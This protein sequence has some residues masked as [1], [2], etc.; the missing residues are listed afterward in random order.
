[1]QKTIEGAQNFKLASTVTINSDMAIHKD[2]ILPL[3]MLVIFGVLSFGM[4]LNVKASIMVMNIM[5]MDIYGLILKVRE[6]LSS[7]TLTAL[8]QKNMNLESE[9]VIVNLWMYSRINGCN[10]L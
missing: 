3:L 1:M 5:D 7:K 10:N 4:N 2:G 9:M 8:K 6:Y